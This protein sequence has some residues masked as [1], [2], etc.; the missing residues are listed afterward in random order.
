MN[1]R[2][3]KNENGNIA[4]I[5]SDEVMINNGQDALDLIGTVGYNYGCNKMIINKKDITEDFFDLANGI[6]GEIMQKV[7]TYGVSLAIVGAFD[8]YNSKSL[9]SLIYESNKGNRILF[10]STEAEALESFGVK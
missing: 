8:Q 3:I 1:V 9:K 7:I 2:V 5:S 6:A 10:K 4:V